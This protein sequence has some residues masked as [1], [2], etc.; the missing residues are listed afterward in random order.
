ML[1]FFFMFYLQLL[2]CLL[3]FSVKYYTQGF[4][5]KGCPL[6]L[7][8]SPAPVAVIIFNVSAEMLFAASLACT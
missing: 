1:I 6:T 4:E 3:G 2:I 5:H 7:N 8:C